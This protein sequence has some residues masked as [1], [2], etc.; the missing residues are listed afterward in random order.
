[1]SQLPA[2]WDYCHRH[3]MSLLPASVLLLCLQPFALR[4]RQP[5]ADKAVEAV[6]LTEEQ[7]EYMAQVGGCAGA[8]RDGVGPGWAAGRV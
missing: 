3:H 6:A 2:L 4:S 7:A 1:M 5:W 8:A